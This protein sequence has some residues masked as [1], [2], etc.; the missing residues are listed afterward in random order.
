MISFCE[1]IRTET[2]ER[3]LS[4]TISAIDTYK[5]YETPVNSNT[6]QHLHSY[7]KLR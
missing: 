4:I 6:L 2:P 1:I 5:M 3:F 7:G